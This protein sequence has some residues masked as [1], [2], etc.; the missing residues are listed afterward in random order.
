MKQAILAI[1]SSACLCLL[2]SS[3]SAASQAPVCPGPGVARFGPLPCPCRDR[4]QRRSAS[5]DRR[6]AG[7]G[8]AQFR[9][10]Y[11]LPAA[12]STAQ[13]IADRRRLRRPEIASDLN[14]Y[15]AQFGLPQCNSANPL[16][17]EGEPERQRHGPVPRTDAAGRWRSRSTSRSRHASARTA[18]SSSWRPA[19]AASPTSQ[20]RSTRPRNS[21]P[22][23]L[24]QLRR[25]RVLLARST[26]AAY[27]HP[28]VAVTVSS[29]DNGYGS[30][31]SRRPR[32]LSSRV[33]GTTLTLGSG[34]AYG[35][36]SVWSGAGSG[37]S[38]YVSAPVWQGFLSA[39]NGKRGTADVAADADP[40]HRRG[41]LRHGQVPGSLGL[42]PGRRHEPL[43]AA[44]RGGL[45]ASRRPAGRDLGRFRALRPPRRCDR[46]ARRHQRLQ[47][48]LLDDHVQGRGRL[49]RSE[50]SRH[51]ERRRRLLG[52]RAAQRP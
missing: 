6:R 43:L 24:E 45:R 19:R 13:T 29:G 41:R 3:A 52:A 8:P 21:A 5:D 23:D 2:P 42:V 49:R 34:N 36:E 11:G 50:R 39:C 25:L 38:L 33:G 35:S 14:A 46:P 37:C 9:G 17:P 51:A 44:G 47:R 22:R 26:T 28:G 30:S 20:P 10:A 31:A 18:R 4:G 32:P 48:Q 16:F 27:N 7:Y 12:A 1:A 15:S 40:E